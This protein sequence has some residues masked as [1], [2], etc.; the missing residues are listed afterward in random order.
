MSSAAEQLD[1]WLKQGAF[2]D[3]PVLQLLYGNGV[4]RLHADTLMKPLADQPLL[5]L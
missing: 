3:E 2:E 4:R 1:D 5:P